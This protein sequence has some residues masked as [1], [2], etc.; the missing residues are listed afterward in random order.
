MNLHSAEMNT[1][2]LTGM[3][4]V[5]TL[6]LAVLVF[7]CVLGVT[8]GPREALKLRTQ[9]LRE[10]LAHISPVGQTITASTSWSQ[11][12]GSRR[13][14]TAHLDRWPAEQPR[15]AVQPRLQQRRPGPRPGL[16]RLGEHD[17]RRV[18]R[19]QRPRRH[20]RPPS[21]NGGQL[22]PPGQRQRPGARGQSLRPGPRIVQS[23]R[24]IL[25]DDQRGGDTADRA[26][27]RPEGRL[28]GA[29]HRPAVPIVGHGTRHHFQGHGDR[30]G[31]PSSFVLLGSRPVPGSTRAERAGHVTP[32]LDIRRVCPARRGRRGPAR[33]RTLPEPAM[34]TPREPQR[35]A[36][37]PGAATARRAAENRQRRSAPDRP[38]GRRRDRHNGQHRPAADAGRVPRHRRR[39][40]PHRRRGRRACCGCCT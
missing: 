7:G 30:G 6:A 15:D 23:Y 34:G 17:G 31:E 2:R 11:F 18:R 39:V 35:A 37:E 1:R 16:R 13:H 5:A 20:R 3:G 8:A 28:G 9:T 40:H 38:A 12:T 24:R 22:P 10:I 36:G 21:G 29:D 25:S 32:L 26:Q 4:A 33:L 19:G 27:V 14:A